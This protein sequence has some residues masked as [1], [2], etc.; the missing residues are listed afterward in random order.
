MPCVIFPFFSLSPLSPSPYHHLPPLPLDSHPHTP[1][2]PLSLP[3]LPGQTSL[4][5]IVVC[6]GTG[7]T[8]QGQEE[9]GTWLAG[10]PFSHSLPTSI[11]WVGHV[12][13]A[14]SCHAFS[15]PSFCLPACG[16][17]VWQAEQWQWQGLL[18]HNFLPNLGVVDRRWE[19]H[20]R[21]SASPCHQWLAGSLPSLPPPSYPPSR[22]HRLGKTP[23]NGEGNLPT[24]F[25][26]C[27]SPT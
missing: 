3:P 27:S 4:S 11:V 1:L 22:L 6:C 21:A 16:V 25:A 13:E 8:G 5:L 10:R 17:V 20:F 24:H 2:P 12:G 14:S 9:E 7:W 26:L 18:P 15:Q 19:P 23:P